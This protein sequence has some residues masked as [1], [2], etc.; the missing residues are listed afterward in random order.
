MKTPTTLRDLV[1]VSAEQFGDQVAFRTIHTEGITRNRIAEAVTHMHRFFLEHSIAAGDR[2]VLLGESQ[3][4]W[5]LAYLGI[6]S[7]G[8]VVVPVLTDFPVADI[9]AIT[10]HSGASMVIASQR[11]GDR[12]GGDG[13]EIS[14][15]VVILEEL[16]SR[17]VSPDGPGGAVEVPPVTPDDCAAILYT[18]GTTGHSKGVMLTHSN[19]LSNVY[20]AN[21]FAGVQPG[22]E[23][24]SVLPLA[25]TYEC[26]LGMLLPFAMGA[27]VNYLDRTMSPTVL[28]QALA[29]VRPHLMLAVPLLI[30]KTVRA[31]VMPRLRR[32]PVSILR[33]IPLVGGVIYRAAGKKLVAAFGGRLRF[34]GIGGAPLAADVERVLHRSGFP[35][36]IGYGLTETAP[37]LAG[38]SPGTNALRSTGTVV[39]G[40]EIRIRD[41]EIQA[42]GPNVMPG[43][44]R[45]EEQTR[46][47]F[48]DDHWFRTGDLGTFDRR[49]RL[50]VQGRIK[51]VIIGSGGENIYPEP[52]EAVINQCVGVVESLVVDAGGRLVARVLLDVEQL[53]E[54]YQEYAQ[55]TA[56]YLEKIRK[57]V[58]EQ[59]SSFARIAEFIEQTEPFEK[60]PTMK[61]KRYLYS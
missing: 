30:E 9:R 18:S 38:T 46:E 27:T 24:L 60:T 14:V 21:S 34:F 29:V 55:N 59:V 20:A 7:W 2:V 33:R 13:A 51:T 43:Y 57:Q 4:A 10:E 3:P 50:Y 32:F 16:F 54:Q 12:L 52:I 17:V 41:G 49:G 56:R 48:T 61:I 40:V 31:R 8:A 53:A 19:I 44:Y 6:T 47:V 35:Y 11:Q 45:N 42:R 37:L 22:E 15:P 39:P 1:A 26:T 58:N 5:P 28:L 23:M 25:H 36:A